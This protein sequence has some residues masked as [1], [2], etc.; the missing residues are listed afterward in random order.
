M[1]GIGRGSRAGRQLESREALERAPPPQLLDSMMAKW[2]YLEPGK[3]I[4]Q[5]G[6]YPNAGGTTFRAAANVIT[7]NKPYGHAVV[8]GNNYFSAG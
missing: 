7:D 5:V 3:D 2:H 1:R 8:G 4:D 6:L